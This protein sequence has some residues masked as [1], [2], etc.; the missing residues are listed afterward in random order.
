MTTAADLVAAARAEIE[1]LRV[2]EVEQEIASG[3]AVIVDIREADELGATG[4][5]V[6]S[7]AQAARL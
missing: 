7:C 2:D 1:N 6:R 4:R 3:D 5:L